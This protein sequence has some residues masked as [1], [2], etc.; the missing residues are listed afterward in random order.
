MWDSRFSDVYYEKETIYTIAFSPYTNAVPIIHGIA[1]ITKFPEFKIMKEGQKV[2]VYGEIK[3]FL[4][5]DIICLKNCHFEFYDIS[6]NPNL[7]NIG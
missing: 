2:K 3:S 7:V 6:T 1:D 5:D 4:S